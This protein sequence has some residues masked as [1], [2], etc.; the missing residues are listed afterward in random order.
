M[1]NKPL[2]SSEPEPGPS[3]QSE[4]EYTIDQ[5]AALSQVPSRTIRYYQSAG[6]LPAPEIRGRVAYYNGG[7]L[8]RLELVSTLQDR[9][10]TIKAICELVA[11]I[12]K[13][14]LDL[15]EWLGLDA[16]LG[17]PWANDQPRVVSEAELYELV[18]KRPAG[19]VAQLRRQKLIE[20][21]GEAF[22][23]PSPG[24][25]Q[26]VMQLEAA[27]LDLEIAADGLSIIRKHARRAAK[28]L[29][30][31]FFKQA[32][33]DFSSAAALSDAISALR[34]VSQDAL[35]LSFG[36]EME[37]VLQELV[38]SGKSTTIPLRKKRSRP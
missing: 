19:L 29:A 30:K 12:D 32:A 3:E 31:Y 16:Q 21:K 20:R 33:G 38:E 2:P 15:N 5:L 6:A 27:G 28:D 36:Q 4:G 10:L 8:E 22:L 11:R 37:R 13:G 34:P 26:A 25:L 14:E 18:G 35:R 9:G 23:V 24:L 7:H 1:P 17:K